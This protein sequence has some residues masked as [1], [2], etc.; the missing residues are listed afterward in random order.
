MDDG[1]EMIAR[2]TLIAGAAGMLAVANAPWAMAKLP[3]SGVKGLIAGA[4]DGALDKLAEPGAFYRDTA[5]RILLPGAGGKL[6]SKLFGMGDQLGL[7]TNLTKSLNDA[8]GKAAGEAKPIF[9]TAI[10]DLRWTDAPGLVAKNDG[11]TR[12][13]QQSAG[14]VLF[15]KV[16][17]LIG[18]AL[19]DVGAYRQLDQL[20]QGSPLLASAGLTRDGLTRSVTEQALKG[21]F[22]YMAGEEAALRRNPA[23]LLKGI[24]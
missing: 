15:T 23:G 13:L 1:T 6:A 19:G 24:F 8:G 14:S 22:H 7:T 16:S 3:K 5:V 12:Y 11:A 9:R 10:D 17:P 2:R 20:S 21:I 18:S 4:S